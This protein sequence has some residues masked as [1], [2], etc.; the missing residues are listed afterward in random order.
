[1]DAPKAKR[2]SKPRAKVGER[3]SAIVRAVPLACADEKAALAFM[4]EMRWG[5]YPCCPHCGSTNVYR[6][7]S[8]A[9]GEREKHGRWRCRDCSKMF[10]VRTGS[11]MEDSK[12][13]LRHWAFAF[14]AAASSKKG[15]SSKQIQRQTGLSYKAALFLMHRIRYAMSPGS[16]SPK[17]DGVVE[18]DETF[19]GGAPR[20]RVR[21][22]KHR[23]R[24]VD[25]PRSVNHWQ[26]NKHSVFAAV[27]RGTRRVRTRVLPTINSENLHAAVMDLIHPSS[28]LMTDERWAYKAI[29]KHMASHQAVCHHERE[30]ARGE[31]TTNRIEGFFALLKRA[32]YGTHHAVSRKH[33]HRYCDESAF[34]Y[35][36]GALDDGERMRLA[37]TLASGRRL[38]LSAIRQPVSSC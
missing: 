5:D 21:Y 32:I 13:P 27:E 2:Q 18:A 34:K 17:L 22:G 31:V 23:G 19:I 3:K 7:M 33:L 30:Y 10:S 1:M 14:W 11:V 28:H 20:Y 12:I 26:T 15:V 38:T 6:M 25:R 8:R 24:K 9:T 35:E 16:E 36:T 4:E 37:I 29:G